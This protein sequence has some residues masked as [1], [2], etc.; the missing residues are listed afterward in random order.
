MVTRETTFIAKGCERCGG[1]L[2]GEPGD[3]RC[4]NCGHEPTP[5]VDPEVMATRAS[6]R[7]IRRRIDGDFV[8]ES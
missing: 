7:R 8:N 5:T 2:R 4:F 6:D 3:L 1:A